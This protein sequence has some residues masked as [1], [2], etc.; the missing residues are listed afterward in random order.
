MKKTL[1]I[2]LSI[3]LP[4]CALSCSNSSDD[5]AQLAYLNY[6]AS[7][8]SK[9]YSARLSDALKYTAPAVTEEA[10][11]VLMIEGDNIQTMSDEQFRQAVNVIIHGKTLVIMSCSPKQILAFGVKLENLREKAEASGDTQLV[12]SIE[13]DGDD[14][15]SPKDFLAQVTDDVLAVYKKSDPPT[16]FDTKIYEALGVRKN[17]VY[18]VHP[19]DQNLAKLLLTENS[20]VEQVTEIQTEGQQAS[21]TTSPVEDK[22]E[23]VIQASVKA[24]ADWI[25]QKESASSNVS[26]S[27]LSSLLVQ[28]NQAVTPDALQ[29][30]KSAQET[31]TH[32][33]M[34]EVKMFNGQDGGS[35]TTAYFTH[36]TGKRENV[37]VETKVWAVC[38]IDNKKEYYLVKTSAACHNEQ[39]FFLD[40]WEY[41]NR[42]GPYFDTC[43][44]STTMDPSRQHIDPAKCDPKNEV[45]TTTHSSGFTFSIPLNVGFAAKSGASIGGG[46]GFQFSDSQSR[47]IP[48][49][50]ITQNVDDPA[51]KW[52]FAGRSFDPSPS[53]FVADHP[54]V[55]TDIQK[56]L[57]VFD[58]YTI[59]EMDSDPDSET[60]TTQLLTTD[61]Y[62]SIAAVCRIWRSWNL[63][64]NKW[65]IWKG[66]YEASH[67]YKDKVKRPCN[68]TGEY[69]MAFES[70]AGATDAQIDRL[71]TQLKEYVSSWG[72]NINYYA[73]G[74]NNVD[75]TAK[76]NFAVVKQKITNNKSVFTH[77][78]I[79]GKYKFYIK[80]ISA[81]DGQYVDSFELTF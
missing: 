14:T 21:S 75:A 55:V 62:V 33:F 64:Y 4:L 48:D 66:K 28:A 1:F 10:P 57:A 70:P 40:Q 58:T 74:K 25:L 37:S 20:S 6:L 63:G 7:Q 42:L 68:A 49:I 38:D 72:S 24:F 15:W 73:I 9:S 79:S 61:V 77:N 71:K 31:F 76:S 17:H 27:E 36:F 80:N 11:D 56:K 13:Q 45:G 22:T 26:K 2:F 23:E 19:T 59:I 52:T 43:K 30:L 65:I 69:I 51:A 18:Y 54:E 35:A 12:A 16:I 5:S 32:N 53:V 8:K 67:T 81:P 41:M 3:M 50:T 34:V 78:N 44:I 47:S 46:P 60:P 39:L 29:M